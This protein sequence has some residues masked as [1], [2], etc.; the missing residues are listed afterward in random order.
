[1]IVIA[2]TYLFKGKERADFIVPDQ[3]D[4]ARGDEDQRKYNAQQADGEAL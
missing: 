3:I 1:M 2:L 4:D